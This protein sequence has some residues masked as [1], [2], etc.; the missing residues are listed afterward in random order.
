[1][2]LA[3]NFVDQQTAKAQRHEDAAA[4]LH[5]I[6]FGRAAKASEMASFAARQIPI[7]FRPY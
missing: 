6:A 4:V 1:V 2:L 7:S 3:V 5:F